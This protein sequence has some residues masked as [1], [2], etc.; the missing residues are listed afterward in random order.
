MGI[1]HLLLGGCLLGLVSAAA[2]QDASPVPTLSPATQQAQTAVAS[3]FVYFN[4]FNNPGRI[5]EVIGI[6]RYPQWGEAVIADGQLCNEVPQGDYFDVLPLPIYASEF[7]AEVVLTAYDI[8]DISV[9]FA[10]GDFAERGYDLLFLM[11]DFQGI[12]RAERWFFPM[13]PGLEQ[14][15]SVRSE[16]PLWEVEQPIRVGL[17]ALNGTYTLLVEQDDAMQPIFTD[18]FDPSGI[19]VGLA[20]WGSVNGSRRVCFDSVMVHSSR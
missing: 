2:A 14:F 6:N 1:R 8:F 4:D 20:M 16:T 5:N 3:G 17:E 12:W 9:G 13:Q 10:I 11:N 7:Y 19:Q 18:T 15:S